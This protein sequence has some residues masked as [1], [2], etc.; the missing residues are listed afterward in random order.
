MVSQVVARVLQGGC[1]GSQVV[2]K[3][4]EQMSK[5]QKAMKLIRLNATYLAF[6]M[7]LFK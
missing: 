1:N 5:L 2:A 7:L 6:V 4:N 3:A